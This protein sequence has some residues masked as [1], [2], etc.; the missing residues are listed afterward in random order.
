M[1]SEI[2]IDEEFDEDLHDRN[3]FRS[4][5]T[6]TFTIQFVKFNAANMDE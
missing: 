4:V 2:G 1:L 5:I 3:R 6:D